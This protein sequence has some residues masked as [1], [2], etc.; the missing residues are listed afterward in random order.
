M[1]TAPFDRRYT[2][3]DD[4]ALLRGKSVDAGTTGPNAPANVDPASYR[5]Q[6]V[7][8]LR[9][10][11]PSDKFYQQVFSAKDAQ[12]SQQRIDSLSSGP[13]FT[14]QRDQALAKDWLGKYIEGGSRG[15]MLPEEQVNWRTI[16]GIQSQKPG[17]GISDEQV[18]AAGKIEYPGPA[19]KGIKTS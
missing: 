6:F 3:L 12:E 16:A 1:A 13:N 18:L 11:P 9:K 15:I 8:Q 2:N 19:G 10:Q 4:Q 17:Q 5:N 7:S 14:D